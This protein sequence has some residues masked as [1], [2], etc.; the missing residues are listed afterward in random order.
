MWYVIINNQFIIGTFEVELAA[1]AAIVNG[2]VHQLLKRFLVLIE[3]NISEI[4]LTI[5]CRS[6]KE[7][8]FEWRLETLIK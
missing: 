1:A 3:M 7:I 4:I 6:L 2:N 8:F 5:F